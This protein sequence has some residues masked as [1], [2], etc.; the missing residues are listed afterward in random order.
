MVKGDDRAT[1]S[2]YL[3]GQY[4]G[5]LKVGPYYGR[6]VKAERVSAPKR[7][8]LSLYKVGKRRIKYKLNELAVEVRLR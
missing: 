6:H 2:A 4:L 5:P 1:N 8:I 3:L 7:L